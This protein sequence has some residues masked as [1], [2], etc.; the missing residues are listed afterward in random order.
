VIQVRF[1]PLPTWPYPETPAR[2][3]R[4]RH[5]FKAPWSST[6]TLLRREL[7]QIGA[8]IDGDRSIVIG[9]G[10]TERDICLDGYPRADA[11]AP[12]HP[13]VEVSFD[14]IIAGQRRRLVY[15]TDVCAYW[16]HNVRSIALGLE[17]LRA[18][19]RYGI[20]R[21]GEQYAGFAQLPRGE[22]DGSPARGR[23][24]VRQHGGLRA[25]LF[26]CHPDHGGS[27]R[28][29]RDVQA[30]RDQAAAA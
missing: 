9:A 4:S 22:D 25:A 12:S 13:G 20:T 24:L 10:F 19:D 21:R 17:A 16:Q 28:D 11:K 29:F 6:L 3:R 2:A 8:R 7:E 26:A 1:R 30:Y 27:E 18:V 23:E 15:A 14:A 5:T